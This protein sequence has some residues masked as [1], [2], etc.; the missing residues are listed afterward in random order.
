MKK[1]TL[2]LLLLNLMIVFSSYSQI[3]IS[4]FTFLQNQTNHSNIKVRFER[5][6]PSVLL[7]SVYT[8]NSGYFSKSMPVGVYN[9][10]FSKLNFVKNIISNQVITANVVLPNR[11]LIIHSTLVTVPTDVST[12]QQAINNAE[13]GDTIIVLPGTY[14]ENLFINKNITLKSNY[15]IS[16]DTNIINTTIINGTQTS[17]VITINNSCPKIFGLTITNGLGR[18]ISCSQSSPYLKN[19]IISNNNG[20]NSGGGGGLFFDYGSPV[21]EN[22]I[23]R[24]NTACFGGAIYTTGANLKI[25]NVLFK[26][27]SATNGC[28]FGGIGGAIYL[29]NGGTSNFENVVFD[30]N[31]SVSNGSVIYSNYVS[32]YNLTNSII[33][34]NTGNY[35]IYDASAGTKDISNNNFWNNNANLFYGCSPYLGVLNTT[36]SNLDS[37]DLFGNIKLNPMFQTTGNLYQLQSTSH[38][39]NAGTNT[40]VNVTYDFN[41]NQRIYNNIVDL[42]ILEY[43]SITDTTPNPFIQSITT[44]TTS[45]ITTNSATSG[46]NIINDLGS[47]ITLRGVCYN[48]ATNPTITNSVIQSGSGIGAF[49]SNLTN[50]L[51]NT[52]YYVR[53]FG[54][55]CYGTVYGTE[56]SFTTSTLGLNEFSINSMVQIYPNPSK[57]FFTIKVNSELLKS[58]YKIIDQLG[59]IVL[60][61]KINQSEQIIDINNLEIGI[62]IISFND[63][64]N[65]TTKIIKK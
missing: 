64:K 32:N 1:I 34:N 42:G 35:A 3:N 29:G 53:A 9:I 23:I 22:T 24:N 65:M 58:D 25:R 43:N 26:S 4:G 49:S 55:S 63:N 17:N 45:N 51:P 38:C 20:V 14:N 57:D 7:D 46:G 50:L 62:Y 30:S 44:N 37:C 16:N 28:G 5:T 15:Y 12:I 39:I 61:G 47:E 19:L 2:K 41:N 21:I 33:S 31:S 56:N 48:I 40:T 52:T 18:G 10:T 6:T 59:R 8:D 36:N 54:T 27:N 11:T 60:N 13:N